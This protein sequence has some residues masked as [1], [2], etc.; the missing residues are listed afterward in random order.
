MIKMCK[1]A[2][3]IV[4]IILTFTFFSFT[5]NSFANTEELY[6]KLVQDWPSIFPDG[7]RNA[8]GPRFFKYILDQDLKYEEFLQFNKLYCAVSGSLISPDVQPDEIF[9]TNSDNDEKICGQ[10]YKC[11]WP[12]L[13][14]VMKYSETKKIKI[15]FKDQS[16]DIYTIVIDNPCNKNDFPELVNRDYF[17]KGNELNKEYTFS[18]DNKLVIGLLHNAQKCDA[19]DI[20]YVQNNQITGPM[21]EARNSMPLGELNSGMGDIFIR[22]AN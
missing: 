22:L 3:L 17:C 11:C 7:N 1:E 6:A 20:D 9:L 2:I 14:D 16:K 13:C 4:K 19:Y 21:C 12:C 18:V 5:S 10:Y 8:A 15:D